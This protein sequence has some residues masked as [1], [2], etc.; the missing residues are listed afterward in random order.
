MTPALFQDWNNAPKLQKETGE[1][2]EEI[3][4]A[5]LPSITERYF[6]KL[7]KYFSKH[8]NRVFTQFYLNKN[9]QGYSMKKLI[10]IQ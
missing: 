8:N 7:K 9:S 2:P 4:T 6:D 1:D 5:D 3:S 10:N